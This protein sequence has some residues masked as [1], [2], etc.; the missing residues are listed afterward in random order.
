V[1]YDDQ[2]NL[3]SFVSNDPINNIDPS[4]QWEI[5]AASRQAATK[6]ENMLNSQ[7]QGT[8]RFNENLVLENVSRS[9]DP[10]KSPTYANTLDEMIASPNIHT[11]DVAQ[12]I[13][14]EGTTSDVDLAYGGGATYRV[15]GTRGDTVMVVSGMP[16]VS[17]SVQSTGG[18]ILPQTPADIVMH[19]VMTHGSAF[20]KGISS[21]GHSLT[22]ENIVRSELSKPLR[23][24]STSHPR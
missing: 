10:N 9:T 4:G 18:R 11:W 16:N 1:G 22:P 8:Y 24:F 20:D 23:E 17:E 21:E 12:T 3:Y 2:A 19:E 14:V 13:S 5:R 7:A 15:P 6:L